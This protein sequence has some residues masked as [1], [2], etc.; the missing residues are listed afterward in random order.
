MIK[1]GDVNIVLSSNFNP[2]LRSKL[3]NQSY[4]GGKGKSLLATRKLKSENTI[5]VAHISR[6]R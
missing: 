3:S 4:G 6:A 5:R 2:H 1:A